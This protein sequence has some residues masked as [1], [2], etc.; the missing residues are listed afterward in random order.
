[1][2]KRKELVAT[3]GRKVKI[4]QLFIW[5]SF[6]NPILLDHVKKIIMYTEF[7][8]L[9]LCHPQ[10]TAMTSQG[11]SFLIIYLVIIGKLAVFLTAVI[12]Y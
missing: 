9:I 7:R 11:K 5:L 10:S 12:S 3:K 8:N 2:L 4:R 1:M 6:I